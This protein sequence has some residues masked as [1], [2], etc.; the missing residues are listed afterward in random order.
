MIAEIGYY[1]L[2]ASLVT[3]EPLKADAAGR[4]HFKGVADGGHFG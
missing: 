3:E 1:L 4:F 2:L